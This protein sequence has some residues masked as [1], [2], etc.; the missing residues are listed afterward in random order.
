MLSLVNFSNKT[1]HW[2]AREA[3]IAPEVVMAKKRKLLWGKTLI[4]TD[5]SETSNEVVECVAK[6]GKDFTKTAKL[7]HVISV[8]TAGGVEEILEK[9]EKPAIEKQAE[10]L[11]NA[12]IDTS[13]E[14]TYGI[15]S[16]EINRLISEENY[17]L[18]VLGSHSKSLGKE[19]LL[20]S[21][22]DSIIRNLTI[23]ALLIKCRG[24]KAAICP[25]V[26]SGNIFFPTDFSENSKIAF[27][28][29]VN[30]VSNYNPIVTLYHVQDKNIVFPH[31]S[32]RLE[33]FNRIDTERLNT[34][35]TALL[36]AGA[37]DA[38]IKIETGHT[39]QLIVNEI[40]N[41]DY[42]LVVMGTQGRGWIEE[43]LI[44]GVAHTV[45]RKSNTSLL[46][47]PY[48]R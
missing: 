7:V 17:Q 10:R 2:F 43:I 29:L 41:G 40:N 13:Y 44:G 19:M 4:A 25:L 47:V 22:S 9:A 11:K 8:E 12:E 36:K 48:K 35:K 27:D 30:L 37:K 3:R 21:V 16:V 23:P 46:L 31:L 5:L 20:G 18:L 38:K 42:N 6:E 26:F 33:E 32:H 34:L 45:I 14:F 24:G 28:T 15:P 1:R 39:K